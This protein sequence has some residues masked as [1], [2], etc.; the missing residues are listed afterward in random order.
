VKPL[1]Y[2]VHS[3][4]LAGALCIFFFLAGLAFIPLLGIESDEALFGQGLYEPRS[5]LYWTH[6]GKTR[7]PIMLMSYVG[8]LKAWIY[9]PILRNLGSNLWTLRIPMLLAGTGS[10]LLF[11]VLLRRI[12]GNRAALIGCAILATDATYLLTSTFDWGPVALQHLLIVGGAAALVRFFQEGKNRSLGYAAFLFGLALFDKA[13]AAWTISGMAA[14]GLL[15]FPREVVRAITLRTIAISTVFC[16]LGVS[17]LLYFNWMTHGSTFSGNFQRNTS[18]I[19]IKIVVLERTLAQDG[20]FGWMTSPDV[21]TEHPHTAQTALQRISQRIA[22]LAREPRR[23][24]LPYALVLALLVSPFAGRREFRIVLF[25][26]V[27]SVV[28][29]I[30][31][32]IN[33][34]TGG[35]IH[36]TILLWPLPQMMIAVSFAGAS[37]RL[38]RAAVPAVAGISA[39]VALSGAL[40]INEYYVKAWRNGG[41]AFWTDGILNLSTYFKQ[42]KPPGWVM[43][44]DWGI[45]DQIRLLHRGR[46][47]IGPGSDQVMKPEMN[48]EDREALGGMLAIPESA[49]ARMR[50]SC[51]SP[52][53][54]DCDGNRSPSSRTTTVGMYTTCT[55]W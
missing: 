29:W 23:S 22:A 38:G 17:P 41:A 21:L 35:S 54:R 10:I 27:T 4:S 37:R 34:D 26:L 36:H 45:S 50:S 13:L 55:G 11:F 20:L 31:M 9:G 28:A 19:P 15:L 42:N 30:Q 24:L 49:R 44:M 1:N 18:E 48:D 40:V 16:V 32:V 8:A 12:S 52:P 46:V 43:A 39:V 3:K 7:V 51:T 33:R 53:R 6:I 14:A 25:A 47:L 2:S 5:E